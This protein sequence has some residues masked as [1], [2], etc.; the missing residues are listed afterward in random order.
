M[1][2]SIL[3]LLVASGALFL[4]GAE[5]T[6]P[7]SAMEAELAPADMSAMPLLPVAERTWTDAMTVS[8]VLFA[9]GEPQPDHWREP[10]AAL[11]KAGEEIFRTGRTIGP[12]GKKTA[13]VSRAFECT[14][15]HNTV[16]EDP[17]LRVS[18]P[19]ARLTYAIEND[20]P[21]LPGTTMVGQ[22]DRTSW[23]NDDYVKKYGSLVEPA[24]KSL[25]G[26]TNLCSKE[27]SLGRVLSD[28]EM[29][30]VL[31]YFWT[32]ALVWSDLPAGGV[33]L[34][35]AET[36]ARRGTDEHKEELRAAV[37]GEFLPASPA[38]FGSLPP[39]YGKGTPGYG[40]EGDAARGEAIYK[41]SC[42]HCHAKGGAAFHRFAD[43]RGSY[44][45]LYG[46]SS[47]KG[48]ESYYYVVREGTKPLFHK[49]M[50][51]FPLQRLSD[52]QVEDLRAWVES[53]AIAKKRN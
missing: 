37:R 44:K 20:L 11:A 6:Q 51:L 42:L 40:H 9:L 12:D 35:M 5:T 23:F 31:S 43:K 33:S 49:Y 50:P 29:D 10:D 25:V 21:L 13:K 48:I 14:D 2:R 34:A 22:V 17:D 45:T 30:A 1:R 52:E 15:C 39:E 16:R 8:A 28:W 46:G 4:L 41:R 27:C 26:A 32:L 53:Q 24:N 36:V 47:N 7:A 18:D 3:L 38:T 19:E